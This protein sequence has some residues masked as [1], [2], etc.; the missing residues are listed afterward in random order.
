MLHNK[1]KPAIT[2]D[3]LDSFLKEL[4]KEYRK[5]AGK[6]MPAEIILIGGAAVL[7]KYGFRELTYDIDAVVFAASAMREAILRVRDNHELPHG[8]LNSDFKKTTSYSEKLYEVSVYYK[9]FSNVL[10]VRTITAKYLLAMKL[11]SSRAYKY[12]L[13]DIV[14]ILREHQM[15]N[16]PIS[17]KDVEEALITL[18]GKDVELSEASTELLDIAFNH[19]DYDALY[20]TTRNSEIE[21]KKRQLATTQKSGLI[22]EESV[23]YNIDTQNQEHHTVQKQS[24]LKTLEEKRTSKT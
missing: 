20:L 14:G 4:G 5:L 13:S 23:S 16:N 3:N 10:T 17:R 22:K 11:M 6:K 1:E 2:K 12:D 7:A 21:T 19:K 8:W 9:T 18:Y 24:L 15:E